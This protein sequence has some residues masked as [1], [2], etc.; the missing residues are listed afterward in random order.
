MPFTIPPSESNAR[1]LLIDSD[2]QEIVNTAVETTL[3]SH[4][5]SAG[6][7]TVNSAL[8][9]TLW[10]DLLNNTGVQKFGNMRIKLGGTN[11]LAGTWG[12]V[13]PLATRYRHRLDAVI[14]TGNTLSAQTAWGTNVIGGSGYTDGAWDGF[15]ITKDMKG[16]NFALA[17][18]LSIQQTFEVTFQHQDAN[19]NES[20]R[21]Y[22]AML[23]L[24][25]YP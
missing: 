6:E 2:V 21:K 3:F 20:Y 19:A 15:A 23:E 13:N 8:R 10:G 16:H 4:V 11:V 25:T 5:I 17:I 22:F 12:G 7:M 24:L 1:V 18:D 14:G 9:F